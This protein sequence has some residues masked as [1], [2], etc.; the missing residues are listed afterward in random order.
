M[1]FIEFKIVDLI[2]IFIVALIMFQIYNLTR[3]TNALKIISGIFILYAIWL[4]VR[5]L[6]MELLSMI[7]GQ[8]IGVGVLALIIVFQNEI[9][10]FLYLLGSQYSQGRQSFLGRFFRTKNRAVGLEWIDPIAIACANMAAANT[11]A[12]VVISR[13]VSLLNFIEQGEKLDAV[14]SSTLLENIFSRNSPL[15]DGAV[16]I[17]NER[18]AAAKCI[19]P[20]TDKVLPVE[21]GTRHRAAIGMSEATDALIIVVSEERGTIS[22]ARKGS[23]RQNI[24]PLQLRTFLRRVLMQST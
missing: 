12:L 5:A 15:H 21:F 14:I 23:V 1:G 16:I 22:I 13:N 24:T 18:I 11:G 6:R 20:S 9:R 4:V 10:R 17:E 2:D 3:G 8:F 19:L 7:L